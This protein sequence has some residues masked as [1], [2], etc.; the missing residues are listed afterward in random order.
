MRLSSLEIMQDIA[1]R[2][3]KEEGVIQLLRNVR[4]GVNNLISLGSLQVSLASQLML[5]GKISRLVDRAR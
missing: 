3:F 2:S 1:N 4:Y 5:T